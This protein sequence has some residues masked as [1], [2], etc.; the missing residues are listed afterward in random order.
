LAEQSIRITEEDIAQVVALWTG[1]PIEQVSATESARL[2]RMESELSGSVIG[3]D[4]AVASVSQ[5]MRRARA[6]LRNPGRPIAGFLFCGPTGVGKT[7]LCKTLSKTF[8]G[9]KDAM[10]RLDMSEYM[11]KHTISKL[12]GAPPGYTGY[13]DGGTLTEAVRRR[14]HSLVLFDEVEKAHPDVF[15]LLLQVLDDGRLTDSTGRTVS[16]AN[17]LVVMTSNLGS[18]SVQKG[19]SGGLGLGFNSDHDEHESRN[20]QIRNQVNDELKSFFRPEF[21]NRLDETVVFRSLDRAEVHAIA[22]LEFAKVTKRLAGNDRPI[23]LQITQKFKDR[24]VEI[25][26]DPAYGA[27]PLRRAITKMLEDTLAEH[28][29]SDSAAGADPAALKRTRHVVVDVDA[30]GDAVIQVLEASQVV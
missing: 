9:A 11:E 18:R 12:I 26:F 10:I 7:E 8:F 23:E 30:Q 25:G 6:G 22:E 29:L 15:N 14:P 3:Q 19:A 28:M 5:A 4:D 27:R 1:I 24:V 17:T 16:F 13:N 20:T 2:L 21:L